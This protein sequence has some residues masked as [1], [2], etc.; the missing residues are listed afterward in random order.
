MHRTPRPYSSYESHGSP[1]SRLPQRC[2]GIER[3]CAVRGG[4]RPSGGSITSD[5]RLDVVL[6]SRQCGIGA[7]G[8]STLPERTSTRARSRSSRTRISS[9]RPAYSWS[10]RNCRVPYCAGRSNGTPYSPSLVHSPCRSGSPHGVPALQFDSRFVWAS[11]GPEAAIASA[12]DADV[13]KVRRVMA[14]LPTTSLRPCEARQRG[15]GT[16]LLDF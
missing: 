7:L 5:V 4:R 10:L 12:M 1:P 14:V 15:G 13:Q 2:T 8:P 9:R 16:V 3:A 6:Y 11:S